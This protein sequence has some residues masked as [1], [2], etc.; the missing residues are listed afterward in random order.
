M[1]QTTGTCTCK[2]SICGCTGTN[3]EK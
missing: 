3:C 2:A 1:C